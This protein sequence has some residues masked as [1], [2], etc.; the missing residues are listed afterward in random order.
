[1]G[2]NFQIRLI[3]FTN[4]NMF[5]QFDRR[6][7]WYFKRYNFYL[8]E[9]D[10]LTSYT[11]GIPHWEPSMLTPVCVGGIEHKQPID[12]CDRVCTEMMDLD[13]RHVF[14]WMWFKAGESRRYC[15]KHDDG[16]GRVVS[17]CWDCD[18]YF[19]ASGFIGVNAVNDMDLKVK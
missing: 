3:E 11:S 14:C 9:I 6:I 18:F 1:M 5:E 16:V 15:L 2:G 12:V 8:C 19:I 17:F 7:I 13:C 10:L 4:L